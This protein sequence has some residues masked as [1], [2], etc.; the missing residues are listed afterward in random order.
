MTTTDLN[1]ALSLVPEIK[2]AHEEAEKCQ[3]ASHSRALEC[4]IKA[5]V[6]LTLAKE[7]VGHGAFGIWRQQNLPQLPQTTASLY[8]RLAEHKDKFRDGK[9]SNTVAVLSAEGKLSLRAA[10]GLLPKR[11]L[12]P[13]QIAAANRRKEAKAAEKKG[14]IQSMN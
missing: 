9:I 6:A 3:R 14:E 10:A 12:T 13:T 1:K 11:P 2:A 7:A 8:M 5:G 4:A